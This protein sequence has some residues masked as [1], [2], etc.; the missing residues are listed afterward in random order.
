MLR[1]P[2]LLL[3]TGMALAADR[4]GLIA[5]ASDQP[6]AVADASLA[7]GGLRHAGYDVEVCRDPA[8]LP[9]ALRRFTARAMR[10]EVLGVLWYIGPADTSQPGVR[11]ATADGPDPVAVIAGLAAVPHSQILVILD[12]TIGTWPLIQ[13]PAGCAVV[14]SPRRGMEPSGGLGEAVARLLVPDAQA[15]PAL[16][17]LRRTD[18]S[19]HVDTRLAR[20]SSL[21]PSQEAA[22]TIDRSRA[23]RDLSRLYLAAMRSGLARAEAVDRLEGAPAAVSIRAWRAFLGEFRHNDASSQDDEDMRAA[24]TRRLVALGAGNPLAGLPAPPVLGQTD[25]RDPLPDMRWVVEWA[26]RVDADPDATRAARIRAWAA[27][28][29]LYPDD[30]PRTDN[31]DIWRTI[32]HEA[33]RELDASG[34]A[35]PPLPPAP[36]IPPPAPDD[37]GARLGIGLAARTDGPG[38]RITSTEALGRSLGLEAGAV[39]VEASGRP[40]A[41]PED[42]AGALADGLADGTIELRCADQTRCLI[43]LHGEPDAAPELETISWRGVIAQG[44][45]AVRPAI[46]FAGGVAVISYELGDPLRLL[47]DGA[48]PA[49]LTPLTAGR[50]AFLDLAEPVRTEIGRRS[51]AGGA[52]TLEAR[53]MHLRGLYDRL[54]ASNDWSAQITLPALAGEAV[55]IEAGSTSELRLSGRDAAGNQLHADPLPALPGMPWRAVIRCVGDPASLPAQT[56]RAGGTVTAVAADPERIDAAVRWRVGLARPWTWSRTVR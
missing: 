21:A 7:S 30:D 52:W 54:G 45:Q 27:V 40:L 11:L 19:L 33:L 51:L 41:R 23:G 44:G 26:M 12:A 47:F 31:D 8:G 37:P 49:D 5:I 53:R 13:A 42:L 2:A 39:V 6:Q 22:A 35:L 18:P 17:Q 56:L 29:R 15:G 1:L 46:P 28:L 32:A 50:T 34:A 4:I 43:R 9:A 48:D 3:C 14:L 24:A 55:W 10:G 16:L 38:V 25:P 20:T 36:P